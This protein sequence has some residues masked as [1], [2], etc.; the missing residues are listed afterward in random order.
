MRPWPLVQA[1]AFLLVAAYGLA[2]GVAGLLW[3]P[4][5]AP[6]TATSLAARPVPQ[7]H[8]VLH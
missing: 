3:S 7:L 2:C 4:A 6:D 5:Y 8:A 1:G